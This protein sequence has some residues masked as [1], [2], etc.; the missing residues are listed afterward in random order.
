MSRRA[1]K[2]DGNHAAIVDALRAVGCSVQSLAPVG[3]GCPD[4]L[5][6]VDRANVLLEI[7]DGALPPSDRM[8][9]PAQKRWHS[10]WCGTAHLAESVEQA[11]A[12]VAHYRARK[13]A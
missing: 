5:V 2:V 12:I 6:G 9:T 8:F 13:R 1:A 3:E 10:E 11:L 7:K 4:L